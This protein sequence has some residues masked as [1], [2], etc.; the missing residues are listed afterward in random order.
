MSLEWP[1][2]STTCMT[3]SMFDYICE[4]ESC[5]VYVASTFHKTNSVIF[6][7]LYPRV[8]YFWGCKISKISKICCGKI[9][10]VKLTNAS[11]LILLLSWLSCFIQTLAALLA[12]CIYSYIEVCTSICTDTVI[13]ININ[14]LHLFGWPQDTCEHGE[15]HVISKCTACIYFTC[16]GMMEH[17]Y[18]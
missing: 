17:L 2:K 15:G 10:Q 9:W 5:F 1:V 8:T 18:M 6:N 12:V 3:C 16:A 14:Q 7:L 11:V 4:K 13:D